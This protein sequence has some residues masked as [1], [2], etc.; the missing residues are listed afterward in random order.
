MN[1][2]QRILE[3]VPDAVLD[4]IASDYGFTGTRIQK[5]TQIARQLR[6]YSLTYSDLAARYQIP[7]RLVGGHTCTAPLTT[8]RFAP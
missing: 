3:Q 5:A 4:K 7:L 6:D 8:G 1:T 2:K